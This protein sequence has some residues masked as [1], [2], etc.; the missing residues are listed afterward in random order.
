MPT[1]KK[2]SAKKKVTKRVTKSRALVA[3]R[4]RGQIKKK[5]QTTERKKLRDLVGIQMIIAGS[6]VAVLVFLGIIQQS[7]FAT[8]RS[9]AAEVTPV[10]IGIEHRT[11]VKIGVVFARK[12]KA[13]YVALQN[14]SDEVI[15]LSLPSTW[16]RTEVMGVTLAD[17]TSEIPVFGFVRWKLPAHSGMRMLLPSAPSSVFF[18]SRSEAIASIEMQMIDLT[19][20]SSEK[21][22]SLIQ[23][24]GALVQLWGQEE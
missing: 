19:T 15:Y 10:T 22:V 8:G 6:A 23:K 11:P 3:Q 7:T 12:E 4:N 17:V 16:H 21:R 20:L 9:S 24:E 5:I 13:G 18:D 2:T 1:K 14:N